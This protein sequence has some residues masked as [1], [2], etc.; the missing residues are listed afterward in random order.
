MESLVWISYTGI[1]LNV[2]NSFTFKKIGGQ[3]GYFITVNEDTLKES[4]FAIA[5]IVI[6]TKLQSKIEEVINLDING[7][8]YSVKF[9]EVSSRQLSL[10]IHSHSN[11]IVG[12]PTSPKLDK[13]PMDVPILVFNSNEEDE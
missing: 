4:S 3:C 7:S 6:A 9:S 10:S 12:F 8:I 2:W 5:K 11:H 1:P 13:T